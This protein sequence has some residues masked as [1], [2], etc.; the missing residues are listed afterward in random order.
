MGNGLTGN[1]GDI[2]REGQDADRA[3]HRKGTQGQGSIAGGPTI[4]GD[5][6]DEIRPDERDPG[7]ETSD[8][9]GDTVPMPDPTPAA[10]DTPSPEQPSPTPAPSEVP[11]IGAEADARPPLTSEEIA[12]NE[13]GNGSLGTAIGLATDD[14]KSSTEA[15]MER[16]TAVQGDAR[17]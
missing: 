7:T 13:R 5:G 11:R 10:P 9:G 1:D 16:A 8:P 3:S 15:A 6:P 17:P 4:P 2:V 12:S 14:T